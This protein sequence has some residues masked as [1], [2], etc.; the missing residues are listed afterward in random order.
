M[1][2]TSTWNDL[3]KAIAPDIF[4]QH[5]ESS[6]KRSIN[7]FFEEKLSVENF[8]ISK[9]SYN[10]IKFQMFALNWINIIEGE[11]EEDTICLTESGKKQF[12]SAITIKR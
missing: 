6:F 5:P 4:S 7:Q 1:K 11:T 9:E 3:F 2:G 8:D 10:I 12:I